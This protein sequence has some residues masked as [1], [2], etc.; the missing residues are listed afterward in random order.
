ML[1]VA[2]C[3]NAPNAE[4]DNRN[5]SNFDIPSSLVAIRGHSGQRWGPAAGG[6]TGREL[7]DGVLD[8]GQE[9]DIAVGQVGTYRQRRGSNL[10]QQLPSAQD[11]GA[12]GD[13]QAAGN[14][15]GNG[16]HLGGE[17][18]LRHIIGQGSGNGKAPAVGLGALQSDT[19]SCGK[20]GRSAGGGQL[21]L[22]GAALDVPLDAGD[23][24]GNAAGLKG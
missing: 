16:G 1:R 4:G 8:L 20:I 9:A 5:V 3:H 19:G 18:D 12:A 15:T 21:E 10:Q 13:V 11:L 23:P 14:L 24:D 22:E 17:G 7:V 2:A 6:N